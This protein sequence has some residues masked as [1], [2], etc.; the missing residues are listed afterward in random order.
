M[1]FKKALSGEYDLTSEAQVSYAS[2][3]RFAKEH[4]LPM[5]MVNEPERP[6]QQAIL[7]RGPRSLHGEKSSGGRGR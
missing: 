3:R 6:V 5:T 4:G 2:A 7:E 1:I